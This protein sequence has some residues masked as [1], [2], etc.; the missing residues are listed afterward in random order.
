M[1]LSA[2]ALDGLTAADVMLATPKTLAPDA[3]VRDA[4]EAFSNEHVQMLLIG[5]GTAFRGAVTAIPDGADPLDAAVL[6]VDSDA[7][8][9]GPGEPAEAA[10]E[11][12]KR[13][14]HRRV[15]VLDP[16]G[17]LLGLVCL[18]T[19][20]TGFCTARGATART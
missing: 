2:A 6:Y 18:N 11:Q 4:R 3:S 15:V 20:L 9:I 12:A 1:G 13:S 19:T 14:P 5:D 16:G 8:T 7:E 10:F 17:A